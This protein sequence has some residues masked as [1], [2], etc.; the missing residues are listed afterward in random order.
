M[1][2]A[3]ETPSLL[4]VAA[5]MQAPMSRINVH[6]LQQLWQHE[7]IV[8]VCHR[9][10]DLEEAPDLAQRVRGALGNALEELCQF[11]LRRSD[12]FQRETAYEL[13]FSWPNP[14]IE[15]PYGRRELAVPFVVLTDIIG[16]EVRIVIRLFGGAGIHLRWVEQAVVDALQEGVSLRRGGTRVSFEIISSLWVRFDGASR[17]WLEGAGSATIKILTP[18]IIRSGGKSPKKRGKF[19]E[20]LS[21]DRHERIA[22]QGL[23]L[24][25]QAVLRSA[26]ARAFALA[27]W[28]GFN[29]S[30][31]RA[32]LDDAIAKITYPTSADIHPEDWVRFSKRG[33]RDPIPVHA[34]S[35]ELSIAGKLGPLLPYLELAELGFVGASCASG[36]GRIKFIPYP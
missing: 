15:T 7:E 1:K 17:D 31:E 21:P 4:R 26:V 19:S 18:V 32:H 25:P 16:Q 24:E 34:Y 11:S 3:E 20:P 9:P 6:E 29:L 5:E 35:G 23:R 30:A 13:L 12:P 36:F 10:H 8:V 14:L 22:S 2:V 27:P 28:M 33:G